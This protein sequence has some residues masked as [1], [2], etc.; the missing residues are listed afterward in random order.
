MIINLY[1]FGAFGDRLLWNKSIPTG[2]LPVNMREDKVVNSNIRTLND[3]ER[4]KKH[5]CTARIE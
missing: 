3:G 4:K 1:T 5:K 2:S